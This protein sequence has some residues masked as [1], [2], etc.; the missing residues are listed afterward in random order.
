MEL[1]YQ[2]QLAFQRDM[3]YQHQLCKEHRFRR[4]FQL[5][6]VRIFRHYKVYQLRL[7]RCMVMGQ[8]LR[9]H[10]GLVPSFQL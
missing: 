9:L 4:F 1:G 3:V 6:L 2:L 8:L 10:K 7:R 5:E